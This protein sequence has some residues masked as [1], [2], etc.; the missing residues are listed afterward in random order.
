MVDRDTSGQ[1]VETATLGD[2]LDAF[3]TVDGPPVVTSADI[4][5]AT[6]LSADSARRKLNTLRERGEVAKRDTAGRVVLYWRTGDGDTSTVDDAREQGEPTDAV[7][8]QD[9][10]RDAPTPEERAPETAPADTDSPDEQAR[11][12][13]RDL[14]LPGQGGKLDARIDGIL[15]LYTALRSRQSPMSKG[16]LLA[17]VDPEEVGYASD[18]SFWNNCIKANASQGRD[19]NAL[20]ALPG[21]EDWGDGQYRYTGD[22]DA[23]ETGGVYDPTEEF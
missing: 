8:D 20:V 14:D 19:T 2:V 11:A 4:A 21:V 9:A 12:I 23:T 1:Y 17:L 10:G 16:D 5:D 7:D 15:T 22:D 6:G 13:L 18:A 3:D